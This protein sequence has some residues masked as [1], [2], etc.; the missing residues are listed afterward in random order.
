MK[1]NRKSDR[2][3][4]Y[5]QGRNGDAMA[6]RNFAVS[7]FSAI[8]NTRKMNQDN[9]YINGQIGHNP[10][11]T[12]ISSVGNCES[13]VFAV[14]DGMGGESDGE[15]ASLI[16]VDALSE[17]TAEQ[18]T[19]EEIAACID[20]ANDRIVQ[21][22]AV[23]KKKSGTTIVMAV[24]NEHQANIYNIGDSKCLLYRSGT[25]ARL[26][27]D[28]TV[29]AQM[30]E[31]GLL[32]EEQAKNDKRSHQLFQ[33]IGIPPEDMTLSIFRNE[34]I[35]LEDGDILILCSDGMTDGLNHDDIIRLIEENPDEENLAKILANAAMNHGSRDNVTVIT[36]KKTH[37]KVNAVKGLVFAAI[38][39]ASVVL[40]AL[41]GLLA[42]LWL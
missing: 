18:P 8:G 15:E 9:F 10:L 31:A 40:G 35:E 17:L 37:T 34:G 4:V 20:R 2:I 24:V 36:L 26:S 39:L 3:E 25:I 41:G 33:H 11:Q 42:A 19:Y 32:T 30:V 27:K 14:A 28:H 12:K 5:I 23:T 38:C 21:R 29:I 1:K 22:V 13:G 7:M 6:N 16:A